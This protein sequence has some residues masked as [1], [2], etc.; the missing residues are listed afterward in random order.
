MR[1]TDSDGERELEIGEG[2]SFSSD[3]I[4][5]HEVLNI[6]DTTSQFLIIE[7]KSR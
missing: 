3:G 1:I 2:V 4:A 6:G 7:D 5:W